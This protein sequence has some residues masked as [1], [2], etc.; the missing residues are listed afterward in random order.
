MCIIC[1]FAHLHSEAHGTLETFSLNHREKMCIDWL[2]VTY[3][4]WSF[5]FNCNLYQKLVV[6]SEKRNAII[7]EKTTG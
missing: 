1:A 7:N 5:R 2:I 6:F 3:L 4:E